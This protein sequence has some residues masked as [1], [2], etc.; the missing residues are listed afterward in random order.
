MYEDYYSHYKLDTTGVLELGQILNSINV[1][2]A[3]IISIFF[4]HMGIEIELIRKIL[5]FD[6]ELWPQTICLNKEGDREFICPSKIGE[7]E[8]VSE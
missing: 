2:K 1:L 4:K 6:S 7:A 3:T 5:R 8:K